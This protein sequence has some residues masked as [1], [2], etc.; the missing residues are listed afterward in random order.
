[1]LRGQLCCDRVFCKVAEF[2]RFSFFR[3]RISGRVGRHVQY[4]FAAAMVS[5][6]EA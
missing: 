3:I 2:L 1:M 5:T 6:V 4:S